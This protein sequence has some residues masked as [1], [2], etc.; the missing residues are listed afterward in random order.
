[1]GEWWGIHFF[2]FDT[3]EDGIFMLDISRG[4][5]KIFVSLFLYR[6]F[7]GNLNGIKNCDNNFRNKISFPLPIL[8]FTTC[9]QL[10]LALLYD[11]LKVHRE[12]LCYICHNS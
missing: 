5:S 6:S 2:R 3:F 11:N 4:V 9:Y 10:S 8:V 7:E 12:E 1:M